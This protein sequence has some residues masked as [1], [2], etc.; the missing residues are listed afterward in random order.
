VSFQTFFCQKHLTINFL[1]QL[2]VVFL[3]YFVFDGSAQS[4]ENVLAQY[5][6]DTTIKASTQI[7]SQLPQNE[8]IAAQ[9]NI[10]IETLKAAIDPTCE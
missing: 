10:F 1:F 6:L 5:A 3:T 4:S 8:N 2:F 7:A 9:L